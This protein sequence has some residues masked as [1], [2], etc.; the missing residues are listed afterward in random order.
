MDPNMA[1][2]LAGLMAGPGGGG[3]PVDP[4]GAA[5]NAVGA[6][7]YTPTSG[8]GATPNPPPQMAASPGMMPQGGGQ[9]GGFG[10]LYEAIKMVDPPLAD[11]FLQ[12][13]GQKQG[14]Q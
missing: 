1:Q 4:Y 10:Q 8:G 7:S 11:M 2:M 12:R 6:R 5:P 9:G 14:P 3:F 13:N